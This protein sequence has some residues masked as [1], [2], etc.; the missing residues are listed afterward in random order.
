MNYITIES[1]NRLFRIGVVGYSPPSKYNV[2]KANYLLKLGLN[3]ILKE[4]NITPDQVELVS[5]LTDVGI[6]GQAYHIAKNM[7][8]KTVGIACFKAKNF[9][10][11]PVDKKMMVG[12]NWGDESPLFLKYID[13]LLKI[14]GGNQS[15]E[16]M[17]QTKSMGK[18]VYV[19]DL[20]LLG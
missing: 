20:P 16:E 2:R 4:H 6:P 13:V 12:K 1:D 17:I 7:N 5:G 18:K 8:M 14:G 10:M 19:Y 11:F 15:R 3:K 9:P